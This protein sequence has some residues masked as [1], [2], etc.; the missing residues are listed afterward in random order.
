MCQYMPRFGR[1]FIMKN[2]A[3]VIEAI[4]KLEGKTWQQAAVECNLCSYSRDNNK[5]IRE[6]NIA[7]E[8]HRVEEVWR[9]DSGRKKRVFGLRSGAK[10]KILWWDPNHEIW[11]TTVK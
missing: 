3:D 7:L 5:M 4:T 8:K 10:F 2:A 6:A 11:P 9:F 1:D